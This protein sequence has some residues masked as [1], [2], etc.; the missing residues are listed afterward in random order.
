MFTF[1]ELMYHKIVMRRKMND[2]LTKWG[3]VLSKQMIQIS[4]MIYTRHYNFA[5][6]L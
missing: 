5:V 4:E 3:K 1:L 6:L 2:K